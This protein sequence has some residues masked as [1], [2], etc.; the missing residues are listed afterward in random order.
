MGQPCVTQNVYEAANERLEIIFSEF[1]NVILSFSGG[2]DSSVML[3]LVLDFMRRHQ[4]QKKISVY[5]LDYEGQY[6][7][8][9]DYVTKIFR[10]N[11][12]LIEPYWCCLPIAAQ[13][14]VSMYKDHWIPWETDKKDIWVREMPDFDFIIN[15]SNAPFDFDFHGIWDYEFNRRFLRWHHRQKKATKTILLIGIREQES[16][17]RYAAIHKKESM[18]Q[19]YRFTTKIFPDIYHGYPIHDW[20][21]EDIWTA[22]A[23]FAWP[24]NEIY[25]L[26]HLAGVS[27]R[28]M[29]V[30]SPF[31]D[32]ATESLKLYR[33]IEPAMWSKLVGRVN[34]A[35]FTA[36]YGGTS[37]MAWKDIKLPPNH[38][39]KSYL[40][41]LL[42]TLP[43]ET[44]NRYLKK[45]KTSIHYWT[46]RGGA[47]KVSTV[48][49][50]KK[51]H[52]DIEFL[53]KPQ[54]KRHYTNE[55]EVV[56]FAD[57]PDDL[58]IKDFASVPTYKRMCITILKND[59]A[60]KYMGFGQ[61]KLELEK[62]KRALAKY[63]DIL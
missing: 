51:L 61:T 29:R 50:L 19:N 60:C 21:V 31:N 20:L 1:D 35:N 4:I 11:I 26:Y 54:S 42:T 14:A 57:Y 6:T 53:G 45:F 28:N 46:D 27:L 5:H 8:T 25:D 47:L 16:L 33:V 7:A 52:L 55:M 23:K 12:D 13:S 43:E 30:A 56:R 58:T 41:F 18:Y 49:E 40:E 34:G 2:K 22:N 63:N 10:E 62:R 59:Y 36:I 37:A 24:Y 38:T 39:W 9:T 3:H 15:E 17:N 48:E 32:S 44:R